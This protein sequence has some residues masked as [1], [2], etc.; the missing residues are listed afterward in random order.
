MITNPG[1]YTIPSSEYHADPCPQP[2]L[3]SS[4]AKE[5]LAHSPL[6][7]ML[8]HPRLNPNAQH[9]ASK[10]MDFGSVCHELLLGGGGEIQVIYFD[11]YKKKEAQELRDAAHKAGV[12][13]ILAKD[14]E[15]AR[16]VV[17]ALREQIASHQDADDGFTGKTEQTLI[18]Q[19]D[20]G[21]WCRARLDG[22]LDR[23]VDDYKTTE[24][25]ANPE[26]WAKQLYTMG[27]DIQAA[28][29]LRGCQKLGLHPEGFRFF[30]QEVKDEPFAMSVVAID[31]YGL[32]KANEKV[33]KAI[34]LYAQCL[35]TGTWPAYPAHICWASPPV[36]IDKAWTDRQMREKILEDEGIHS[37]KALND[38]VYRPTTDGL[39]ELLDDC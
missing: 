26:A 15:R 17:K 20:N 11:N 8:K 18:W 29:Y 4:L 38:Y 31:P 32:E 28:F 6:H 24:G 33:E 39:A 1:I 22:L 9:N 36:F 25:S 21:I 10:A 35:N 3:S 30:V 23:W 16:E 12:A 14:Y 13:P 37:L 5:L 34:S 2:S 7:A 27:Y 19:E